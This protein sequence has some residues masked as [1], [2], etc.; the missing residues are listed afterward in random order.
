MI[1]AV[2][3]SKLKTKKNYTKKKRKSKKNK[4]TKD[5]KLLR[6][7]GIQAMQDASLFGLVSFPASYD[8]NTALVKSG[9]VTSDHVRR[10]GSGMY[11]WWNLDTVT[12]WVMWRSFWLCDLSSVVP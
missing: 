3:N 4:K 8:E 11:L 1:S 5:Y 6:L 10:I 2:K 7:I 9:K 12:Y